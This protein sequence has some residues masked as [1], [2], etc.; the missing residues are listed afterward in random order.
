[1]IVLH[2]GYLPSSPASGAA[3]WIWGEGAFVEREGREHPRAMDAATVE[4]ALKAAGFAFPSAP[5]GRLQTAR[6][7]FVAPAWHGRPVPSTPALMETEDYAAGAAASLRPFELEAILVPPARALDVLLA[8]PDAMR[9]GGLTLASGDDLDYWTDIARWAFDLLLRRRV[10][11]AAEGKSVVW[12]P[13]LSDPHEKDRLSRFVAAFPSSARTVGPLAP[14]VPFPRPDGLF[15]SP[16]R[17]VRAFLEDVTDA[18]AREFVREVVPAERRK[19]GADEESVAV[20]SLAATSPL[21]V[22]P[23]V[24]GRLR[25]WVLP[26]LEPLPEGALRLGVRLLPPEPGGDSFRLSYHLESTEDPSLQIPAAEIWGEDDPILHRLG[27]LLRH[28][29]ESLLTRLGQAAPLSAPVARSLEE[30]RPEG[31]ELTL[32][33]AYRFLTDEASLLSEAGVRVYLPADGKLARVSVRLQA[34]GSPAGGT[35]AVTR[36]GLE[37]L[38]D[39]DWRISLGDTLLTPAEFEEL[40][41]R[42]IPLVE[43]RGEW[44]LL[45][46]ESLQRTLKI[47]DRRPGGRTTLGDFLRL[48][49]G[50]EAETGAYPV[51]SVEASGWLRNLLDE[52]VARRQVAAFSPPASLDGTLRPYQARG[53]AWLRF[54]T[55][56][57]LGACLADDMGLGKTVQFLATLLHAREAGEP[58]RPSLLVCPTSVADNWLRE[59]ARFAPSLSVAI[60]H[61]PDRAGGEAFQELV[62]RTDL[63]VTTYALA[64]RDRALLREVAWEYVALDE[65]QNVKNPAAA[66]SRAV[67]FLKARRRAAL[68]GTPVENRLSELK[69]I[70]DFLNPGLLGSDESFR[71]TY[72]LPIERRL[73]PDAAQRLRRITTPFLLRR[74]KTDPGVAPDLPEKIETTEF[75]S[76]T[77]EQATLYRAATRSLLQRIGRASPTSR[78][79]R[80]LLLLLRLKQICDHPALFLADGNPQPPRSAKVTRLLAMLDE[81]LAESSPALLFTQFAEMGHLLVRILKERFG[82][83]VL[84]LHGGVPRRLRTEMV[85]RFQEADHPPPFFVLSLKAGGSGLNLTRASHVFHVDRWWNPAVEDQATDRSFRIGQSRNVQ[86]HKFVCKGTLEERIDRMIAEKKDLARSIVGTGESWLTELS[87]AEL[88]DLVTLGREAVAGEGEA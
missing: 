23:T 61:G 21:S 24:L 66:Q 79:A 37:T 72:A 76:L 22:D 10:A 6:L 49:G 3:F 1:M 46:P 80:I 27:R 83:E 26:L 64:H 25:E 11:P 68:T 45:D 42:K 54:L 59:A 50:L 63:L 86:V 52:G 13:V 53:V 36:F 5:G 15:P 43:M 77:R 40:A 31:V 14:A 55:S 85:R 38:V 7:G 81:T 35:P 16:A 71:R 8:L 30:P 88:L 34:S 12:R 78:R 19:P 2:G 9:P 57:G 60:H 51:E 75:T 62:E 74:A 32:E 87:D 73:D 4:A 84:F 33:E 58:V 29:E 82:T 67:R 70:F 48:A 65:A 39:F 28:P 69:A 47:F 18:A 44:V 56:R 17:L 20:A 41:V